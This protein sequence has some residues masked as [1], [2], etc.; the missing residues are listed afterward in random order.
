MG[1]CFAHDLLLCCDF[2]LHEL[3]T[4]GKSFSLA[5]PMQPHHE[6]LGGPS[7]AAL[8]LVIMGLIQDSLGALS[9][10]GKML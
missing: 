8:V 9:T 6:A 5:S 7:P 10:R 2:Y 4:E 1:V 3:Y